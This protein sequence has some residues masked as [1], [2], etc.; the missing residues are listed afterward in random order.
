MKTPTKSAGSSAWLGLKG[1]IY[2]IERGCC[3][4]G[5]RNETRSE[6]F[7]VMVLK[8]GQNGPTGYLLNAGLATVSPE[9]RAKWRPCFGSKM[10]EMAENRSFMGV[11]P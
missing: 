3:N 5:P 6:R 7:W 10:T 9:R 11:F 2:Q 1:V 8:N 4:A